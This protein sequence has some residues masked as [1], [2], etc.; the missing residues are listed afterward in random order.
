MENPGFSFFVGKGGFMEFKTIIA[1]CLVLFILAG[2]GFFV[3]PEPEKVKWKGDCMA[4]EHL[5]RD[6]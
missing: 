3:C 1:M 6:Y 2:L 5:N 4:R